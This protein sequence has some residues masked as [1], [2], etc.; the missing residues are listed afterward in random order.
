M[1]D[2]RIIG[3]WKSD[4]RKTMGYLRKH[5]KISKK[6]ERCFDAFF[7]KMSMRITEK[8]IY[9]H[10]PKIKFKSGRK[11]RVSDSSEDKSE[12]KVIGKDEEKVAIISKNMFDEDQIYIFHVEEK[13]IWVNVCDSLPINI[14]ASWREYFKVI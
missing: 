14:D 7:G 6:Q 12:Y 5:C 3:R 4:K 8:Y 1:K 9:T 13:H 2:K 10:M 11:V